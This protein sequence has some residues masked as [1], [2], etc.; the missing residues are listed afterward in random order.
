MTSSHTVSSPMEPQPHQPHTSLLPYNNPPPH[1]HNWS[2]PPPPFAPLHLPDKYQAACKA[3]M[4]HSRLSTGDVWTYNPL[5]REAAL[6]IFSRSVLSQVYR[7]ACDGTEG[8]PGTRPKNT[9][10]SMLL[11]DVWIG[12]KSGQTGEDANSSTAHHKA[13]ATP[14]KHSRKQPSRHLRYSRD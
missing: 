12:S 13:P 8:D 2:P 1:R 11:L 9:I 10:H 5:L 14:L 3:Y 4:I 7:L 6:S